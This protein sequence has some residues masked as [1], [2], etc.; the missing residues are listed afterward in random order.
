MRTQY[1]IL[2]F[3]VVVFF[4]CSY[5]QAQS[6]EK[7]RVLITSSRANDSPRPETVEHF[8]KRCPEFT[9]TREKEKADY[10]LVHDDTGAGMARNLQ[11]IAVFNKAG[12]A[13]HSSSAK[14]VKGAVDAACEA[15]RE[16]VKKH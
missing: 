6:G 16:D 13:I 3:C 9:V 7:L 10:I 5:S 2:A 14:T 15:I 12:D 11:K 4:A 8:Q 1:L